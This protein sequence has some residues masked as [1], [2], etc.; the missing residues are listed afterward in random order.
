ME[1]LTPRHTEFE[2]MALWARALTWFAVAAGIWGLTVSPP[3]E[4]PLGSALI[5]GVLSLGILVEFVFGGVKVE[6]FSDK[7]R[8]SLGR[9]GWIRKVVP[10]D[11][12]VRVEPVTYQPLR[13]FGG[14]GVRGFGKKQAWTASG[15]RALVLHRT[16]GSQLYVGHPHPERLAERVRSVA[17]RPFA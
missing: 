10:F 12:I 4:G 17:R 9:L 16:D 11:T 2:P 13:E 15:N 14:W 1:H 6:L 5:A 7:M 8:V 3:S